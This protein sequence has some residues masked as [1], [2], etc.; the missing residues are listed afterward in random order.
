MAGAGSFLT[1]GHQR[2][3]RGQRVEI[4]IAG[5]RGEQREI[6]LWRDALVRPVHRVIA[7]PERVQPGLDGLP[8][9]VL[10]LGIVADDA[11]ER[12]VRQIRERD[13]LL[14]IRRAGGGG[15]KEPELAK[16][17]AGPGYLR[18]VFLKRV[19]NRSGELRRRRSRRF[20]LVLSERQDGTRGQ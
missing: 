7:E 18:A 6:A 19:A 5:G 15:S 1:H 2:V 14:V 9:P 20:H 16:R 12:A 11:D 8:T 4:G 10:A 3:E 13:V 17:A